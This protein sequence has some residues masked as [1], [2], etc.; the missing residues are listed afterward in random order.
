M[1]VPAMTARS[2]SFTA[3]APSRPHW[4]SAPPAATGMPGTRP[5]RSAACRVRLPMGAPESTGSGKSDRSNPSESM[6]SKAQLRFCRSKRSVSP[7]WERSAAI[8]PDR[9]KASQS[10]TDRAA[11]VC[12]NRSGALFFIHSRRVPRNSGVGQCPETAWTSLPLSAPSIMPSPRARASRL[13]V[14]RRTLFCRSSA[15]M[16]LRMPPT[17]M[18]AIRFGSAPALRRTSR[19]ASAIF[20]SRPFVSIRLP[21]PLVP[22]AVG[23][24]QFRFADTVLPVSGS[25]RR[26]RPEPPPT[27]MAIR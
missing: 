27:S 14:A 17:A 15:T 11:A 20:A 12:R 5:S 24:V 13:G 1:V 10:V 26:Q 9:T 4:V 19:E 23:C 2:P 25:R 16:V 22:G 21:S 8:F 18:P 6:R 3:P 7:A